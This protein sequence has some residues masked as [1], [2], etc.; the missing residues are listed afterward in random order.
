MPRRSESLNRVCLV[1]REVRPVAELLRFV[2]DPAGRIVFDRKRNL[3]GRGVWVTAE[4]DRVA[5]AARRNLFGRALK[6]KVIVPDD[7][8]NSVADQMRGSVVGAL[9]LARKSGA[10]I[11]G[12]D[13]VADAIKK[14]R[15][16]A[17]LH[18]EEAGA[19]GVAK[20]QSL[21]RQH[22]AGDRPITAV[23][24]LGGAE[25]SLALGR[26]NVIHAALLA[27]RAS[28]HALDQIDQFARFVGKPDGETIA[29]RPTTNEI[30]EHQGI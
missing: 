16:A 20:L 15:V 21:A 11:T 14:G 27:G 1:T 29:I 17:L 26:S 12:F 6:A 4:K 9:S 24:W 30:A 23:H 5:E 2:A 18:A 7:L 3:P 19:D 13:A 25:L 10:L 8:A 28:H 22:K